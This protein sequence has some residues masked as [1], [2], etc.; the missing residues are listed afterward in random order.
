MEHKLYGYEG[1]SKLRYTG[2]GKKNIAW[3][4]LNLLKSI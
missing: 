3:R 4:H 2:W 1:Y